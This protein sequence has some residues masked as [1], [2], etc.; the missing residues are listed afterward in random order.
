VVRL[1]CM[2]RDGKAYEHP[3]VLAV[4]SRVRQGMSRQTDGTTWSKASTLHAHLVAQWPCPFASFGNHIEHHVKLV[5]RKVRHADEATETGAHETFH[6]RPRCRH[7]HIGRNG[8]AIG[9]AGSA[10]GERDPGMT[11]RNW[12]MQ[13][14]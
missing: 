5:K 6:R 14:V 13:E 12:C 2:T 8:V 4:K 1:T 11:Q 3:R 9:V 10:L 7:R